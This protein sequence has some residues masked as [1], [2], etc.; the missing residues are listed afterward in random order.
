MSVHGTVGT[1]TP[2]LPPRFL[3]S[4]FLRFQTL[5]KTY[6]S[7]ILFKNSWLCTISPKY[8]KMWFSIAFRKTF[9]LRYWVAKKYIIEY[10]VWKVFRS[11]E[12]TFPRL[13]FSCSSGYELLPASEDWRKVKAAWLL[14]SR[15]ELHTK[16]K[17]LVLPQACHSQSGACILW[18][19]LF[20]V[21][22]CV[23]FS[24]WFWFF[25]AGRSSSFLVW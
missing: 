6:C 19:D 5:R 8:D 24:F 12:T 17:A 4:Y 9:R 22:C 16:N 13:L 11:R 23:V 20:L 7:T 15:E 14:S 2:F 18:D 25:P 10:D 1:T 21:L 3:N